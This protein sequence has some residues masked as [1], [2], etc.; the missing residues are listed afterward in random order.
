MFVDKAPS[1]LA[2]RPELDKAL[3]VARAG[4]QLVVTKLGRLGRDLGHRLSLSKGLLERGADLVVLDQGIDTSTASSR[5][6]LAV[7][8]TCHSLAWSPSRPNAP[9]AARRGARLRRRVVNDRCRA[10]P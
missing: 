2:S 8:S 5:K 1:K 4:D 7:T 9:A 10:E 6:P 3:M